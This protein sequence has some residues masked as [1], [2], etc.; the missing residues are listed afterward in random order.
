MK[1]IFATIIGSLFISAILV[2]CGPTSNDAI[3]YNDELVNQQ[4]KV[5]EK[6]TVLIDAISKNMPDKLEG[7][8]SDLKKQVDESIS[9]VEKMDAFDGKTDFK[10]AAMKVFNTYKD[11]T[12]NEYND[13]IKYSKIPDSLY[14]QEDDDKVIEL[15]KKIDDKLNKSVDDFIQ[16]QKSFAGKYKFELTADKTEKKE[17]KKVN[18]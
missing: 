12:A 18:E 7:L 10:D 14:T 15:S 17:V 6:E 16:I 1:K 13:M 5:F 8:Y 2:S 4:T 11:V 3:K 9:A